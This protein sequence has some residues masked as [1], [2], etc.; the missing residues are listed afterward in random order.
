MPKAKRLPSGSWH[1]QVSTGKKRPNGKGYIYESITAETKRDAEYLAAEYNRNRKKQERNPANI[2]LFEAIDK[3]IDIKN[4]IL[5][6]TTISSYR[7]IQKSHMNGIINKHLN[8]I[9]HS[10]IQQEVNEL[11]SRLEPKSVRNMH[12]LLSAVLKQF[13]PDFILRT[14]LPPK[15]KKEFNIPDI[16]MIK[17]II[18]GSKNTNIELPVILA[19]W[20]GLRSS[21]ICGLTWDCIDYENKKIIIKQAKVKAGTEVFLKSTKTFAGKRELDCPDYIFELIEKQNKNEKHIV[22]LTSSSIYL[23]FT[24]MLK[25]NNIKHCRFHD[26]RHA[27][28]SIMLILNIPD[29]YAVERMGHATNNMLQTVYQHTFKSAETKYNKIINDYF[30]GFLS[31]ELS[32]ENK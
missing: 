5:S 18:D 7:L 23:R 6:P 4:K 21:E 32:H 3:Y 27:N 12:G 14:S 19:L 17:S 20:L 29:R 10:D 30:N 8:K 2:T 11:S 13:R 9:T 25:K 16:D 1:V 26:L 15:V 22:P 28:A 24:A 31:N